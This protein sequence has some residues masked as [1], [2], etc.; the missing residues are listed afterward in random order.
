M[1][2]V[3]VIL[4]DVITDIR[5]VFLNDSQSFSAFSVKLIMAIELAP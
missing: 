2:Q 5:K 1:L 3:D 4:L